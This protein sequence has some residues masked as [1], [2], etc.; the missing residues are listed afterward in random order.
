MTPAANGD[1]LAVPHPTSLSS[2]PLPPPVFNLC[3]SGLLLQQP[4]PSPP[5]QQHQPPG[6]AFQPHLN[7]S[8]T[9]SSSS[10]LSDS[11]KSTSSPFLVDEADELALPIDTS[12]TFLKSFFQLASDHDAQMSKKDDII[13][14]LMSEKVQKQHIFVA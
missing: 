4:S 10:T 1:C 13:R 14:K 6:F 8:T 11:K 7:M 5:Q 3:S 2:P 9:E 12:A